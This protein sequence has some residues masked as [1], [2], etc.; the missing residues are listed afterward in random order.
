[1]RRRDFIQ[2]IG[3]AAAWPVMARAQPSKNTRL[4]YLAPAANPDLQQ[5]MLGGLR[6]LGYVEG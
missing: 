2:S 3:G 4:G 1:L 5:A 6:D